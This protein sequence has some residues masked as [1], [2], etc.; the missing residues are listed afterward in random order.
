MLLSMRRKYVVAIAACCLLVAGAAA[1]QAQVQLRGEAFRGKPFG[2]GRVEVDI[3]DSLLPNPLGTDGLGLRA[4]DNRLLYP[5]IERRPVLDAA[6]AILSEAKRP[7]V[8]IIG[9]FLD[10][11]GHTNIYFLFVGDGPLE[12]SVA[13]R[14]IDPLTVVPRVA[15]ASATAGC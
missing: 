11:P 6:R 7:V 10:R 15:T 3:T 4:K 12:L 9:G 1:A 14:R 8:K 13:S 5:A 2:V